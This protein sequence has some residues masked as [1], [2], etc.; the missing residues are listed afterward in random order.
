MEDF[1][2]DGLLDVVFSSFDPTAQSWSVLQQWKGE[3][4]RVAEKAR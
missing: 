1:D 2:N 4:R 3:V